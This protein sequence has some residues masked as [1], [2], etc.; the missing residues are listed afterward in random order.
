MNKKLL[1]IDGNSLVFRGF[2]ALYTSLERFT[3]KE[4]VHTSAIYTF[5]RMLENIL[6]EEQPTHVLVAFDH[7]KA[8]YRH[9][10]YED[11][12][13]G[14][15]KTPDALKE[16]FPYVKE[17]LDILG[18][19]YESHPDYEADDILGSYA[20]KA[21]NE[22]YQ[23]TILTGDK[24]LLQVIR[25]NITVA[26]TVKGVSEMKYYTEEIIQEEYQ[27]TPK[28]L[29]DMKALAGD[30]SD[31]IPG[32]RKIGEKTALKLLH[33]YHS[34]Q[35]IYDHIDQFPKTKQKENLL[36]DKEQAFLSQHLATINTKAKLMHALDELA[37]QL[38]HINT[39]ALYQF[40]Q[41]LN[42]DSFLTDNNLFLSQKDI[43]HLSPQLPDYQSLTEHQFKELTQEHCAFLYDETKTYYLHIE[44]FG[45]SYHHG[46]PLMLIVGTEDEY[47]Y[48][49]DLSWTEATWF[50]NW[51]GDSRFKKIVYDKKAYLVLLNHYQATLDHVVFDIS[52]GFYLTDLDIN[53]RTL[54][55]VIRHYLPH[56]IDT[57]ET[58]YGKGKKYHIPALDIIKDHGLKKYMGLI[59]VYPR[60]VKTL[61]QQ[62]Q[63]DLLTEIEL[64]VA[65]VLAQMELEGICV[66]H[67]WFNELKD[68]LTQKLSTL[69]EHI[70]QYVQEPFNINSPQQ[71]G[72]VL[73]EEL[74]LPVIKK[75]KT[76]YSTSVDVLEQLQQ[77]HP[78]IDLILEYRQLMKLQSTY[79]EGMLKVIQDDGKIHT[80]YLQN[81]TQ[82]GR[83]SS[84]DPNLQNIPIRTEEGRL[85]R[86][87]FIP[88]H[89]DWVLV[90]ADY[91][92]IELR[93][94]AHISQDPHLIQAFLDDEDIHTSTAQR[95]FLTS[96]QQQVTPELRRQAKAVNFGIVYGISDYGLSQNIHVPRYQAQEIID[97]YFDQYPKVK[98]YMNDM[99][100]Q[101]KK[102]GYVTTL[103]HRRRYI[104][105]IHAKNYNTRSFAERTA[106]NT[107]IQ[108]TAADILKI[109]MVALQKKL[110]EVQ[111]EAKLLL[112]VHDELILECPKEEAV[113][114]M[115]IV[116][117]V[118]EEAA[119]LS[120]PLK[121][122]ISSGTSWY[123]VK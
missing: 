20:I 29:I 93:I 61:K 76:G 55:E 108:G 113:T 82:T 58:I 11:Y 35:G 50:L 73:F 43:K 87:A 94:L 77:E 102:E 98:T 25:P 112:Q 101:A 123:D 45:T 83:L 96:K 85:I 17:L 23:V 44:W 103:Y 92:Q 37:Y 1:L 6:K 22:G 62:Q 32:V 67:D 100:A 111:S 16:Q 30:K 18:I 88:S 53:A 33:K 68:I 114:L 71:L 59:F 36:L 105:D 60:I 47:L 66:D 31:H 110:K 56:A 119:Q 79:V 64:P 107:P 24:D 49:L 95:L 2:Y 52:L 91:S 34:L 70:Y 38:T 84:V 39:E 65:D 81:L 13:A 72:H 80:R 116:K 7:G 69:E 5:H 115:P 4:G 3:N 15:D 78:I 19:I 12:K 120:V 109:A 41:T 97:T 42:F 74:N 9:Q 10:I 118:M 46:Q 51:L 26:L 106:I 48:S 90:A 8:T 122:D 63:W 89:K 21:Q 27:L 28:Q 121:V 57:D 40:Y 54:P 117:Q 99:I 14:R 104:P 75:T 86:K